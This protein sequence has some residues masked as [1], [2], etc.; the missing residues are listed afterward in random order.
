MDRLEFTVP[1]AETEAFQRMARG[2]PCSDDCL[3]G[4]GT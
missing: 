3:E 1:G 4:C 2:E